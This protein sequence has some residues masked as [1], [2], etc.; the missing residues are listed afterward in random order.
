M[1]RIES[2]DGWLL[3]DR[4]P[5]NSLHISLQMV[6][7]HWKVKALVTLSCLTLCHPMDCNSPGSS[8]NGILRQE[9]WSGLPSPSPGDLPNLGIEP[10]SFT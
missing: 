8:A 10:R 3:E 1:L 5:Y 9:Y 6:N 7:A 4:Q 2:L